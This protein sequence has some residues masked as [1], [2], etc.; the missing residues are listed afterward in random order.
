MDDREMWHIIYRALCM[1]VK[2][3]D[4]R[5]RFSGEVKAE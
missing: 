3:L 5:F 2:A 1:V 4:R